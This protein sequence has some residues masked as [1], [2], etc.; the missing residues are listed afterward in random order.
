M[1]PDDG[2]IPVLGVPW[3]EITAEALVRLTNLE[4]VHLSEALGTIRRTERKSHRGIVHLFTND[5]YKTDVEPYVA[6][7]Q[8]LAKFFDEKVVKVAHN[9]MFPQD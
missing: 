9:P 7:V 2:L 6:A 5:P 1:D 8:L 4:C 3:S